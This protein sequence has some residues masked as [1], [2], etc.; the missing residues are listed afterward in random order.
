MGFKEPIGQVI[1]DMGQDWHVV[2]VVKDFIINSP[3]QPL[4]PMF[5]A[6]AKG[7]F[8]VIHIKLNGKNPTE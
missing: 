2:G 3:Y 5:I 1:K 8:N 7:W 4:E 6:G